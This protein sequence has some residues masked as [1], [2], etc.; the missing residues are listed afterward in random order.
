MSTNRFGSFME[1]LKSPNKVSSSDSE[2]SEGVVG[3]LLP[4]LKDNTPDKELIS[5][6]NAWLGK[7]KQYLAEKKIEDKQ[8]QAHNYWLG[9][10]YN[11]TSDSA[12]QDQPIADNL[13][14]KALETFLPQATRQNPEP[15]V[16]AANDPDSQEFA[17]LHREVL[18]DITDTLKLKL[19]VKDATR[20]WALSLIGIAQAYWDN[21]KRRVGLDIIRPQK[22]I[23]DPEGVIEQGEYNGQYIGVYKRKSAKDLIDEFGQK[24]AISKHIKNGQLGTMIQYIEWRTEE[25]VFWTL[26]D[27]VLDKRKNPDWND[28]TLEEVIDEFGFSDMQVVDGLNHFPH[29]TLPFSFISVF[30]TGKH[31]HD[32]TSLILQNL[33][34][35]DMVNKKIRQIDKNTDEMNAGWLFD[36]NSGWTKEK[37]AQAIRQFRQG[38]GVM[39]A[40]GGVQKLS[41]TPLPGDVYLHLRDTRSELEGIFG[42]LGVS[43]A[44]L[45]SEN[46]ARGKILRR[47]AD[48]SRIG[49]GVSEY[50]EQFVDQIYNVFTQLIYVYYE[51]EDLA[52]VLGEEKAM[53]YIQLKEQMRGKRLRVSVKEGSL[54]PKDPL[55]QRN[56]AIDLYSAGVLRP[57]ELFKRLEFAD[58]EQAERDLLE[59]KMIQ[60]NPQQVLGSGEADIPPE[61]EGLDADPTPPGSL[62]NNVPLQ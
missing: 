27:T 32:E 24:E 55:T 44:G 51:F 34:N 8:K 16:V 58:P 37:A 15:L 33:S 6:K 23:F 31:P 50:I 17:A 14:F 36:E 43:P 59:W 40:I 48:Q 22:V 12:L 62:L 9:K 28:E 26:G 30:N 3:E 42:T 20:N 56:E 53:R 39:G 61:E 4:E 7:Y 10:Q 38:K 52:L 18:V 21:K 47:E 5:L 29:R 11:G 57:K 46:T 13:V 1:L 25:K 45:A 54:I 60:Q 35:Q 49:G 19:K 2:R 41:G